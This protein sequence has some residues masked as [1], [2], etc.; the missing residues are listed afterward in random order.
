MTIDWTALRQELGIWRAQGLALPVWWRDDDAIEPTQALDRLLDM[1]AS[2][3]LPVHVAVIPEPAQPPLANYSDHPAFIPLVH[4][5]THTNTAPKGQKKAEF[6]HPRLDALDQ[7]RHA[8]RDM[9]A[10]FGDALVEMFVPPWNRI[11]STV[12][13]GLAAQGYS[14]LSTYTPRPARVISGLVQIN[15]HVDPIHW[16]AGG[17]LVRADEVIAGLV[18][19]L[20]ARRAGDTDRAEP[21]G[22]LTHHLVHD[23]D[24]WAFTQSCLTELLDGGAVAC[25]LR[26]TGDLP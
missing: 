3:G 20:R 21:L 10:L 6:G 23:P 5:W 13:D 16:K 7:T 19:T 24:I 1:G 2:L 18:N 15:C 26:T 9:R 11:D 12:V 17:G 22:F 4:G 8:L 14:A 25:N